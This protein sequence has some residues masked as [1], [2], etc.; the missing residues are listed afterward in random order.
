MIILDSSVWVSVLLSQDSHH[1]TSIRWFENESDAG[2]TFVV[3]GIFLAEIA[4]ATSRRTGLPGLAQQ[5]VTQ[6]GETDRFD[7]REID[8]GIAMLAAEFAAVLSLRGADA[9]YVAL[10]NQLAMPL[11]TWDR[12]I[13]QRAASVIEVSS[14]RE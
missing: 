11:V 4:G 10:A 13:L 7:V 1:L 6:I 9:I 3:P 2:Q 14:P 12:E 8:E 5:A